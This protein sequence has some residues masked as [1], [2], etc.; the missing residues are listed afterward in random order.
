MNEGEGKIGF[1]SLVLFMFLM[2]ILFLR[3]W[4][5]NLY[6]YIFLFNDYV[7]MNYF[8]YNNIYKI[9][10][11]FFKCNFMVLSELKLINFFNKK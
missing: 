7:I 1:V 4:K 8:F 6:I 5:K 3:M 2:N 9:L 10:L 11:V